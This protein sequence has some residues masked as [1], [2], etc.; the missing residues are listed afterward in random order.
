MRWQLADQRC[1]SR[2]NRKAEMSP[3]V[4][5]ASASASRLLALDWLERR[6]LCARNPTRERVPVIQLVR[7]QR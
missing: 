7:F 3:E 6:D 2:A 4:C 1:T 5:L